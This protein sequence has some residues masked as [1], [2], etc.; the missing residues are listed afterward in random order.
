[1]ATI[2]ATWTDNVSVI[3]A[4][5]LARGSVSRTTL[6]LRTK[7]GA[8]LM[9]RLGRG[10]TTALSAGVN[11]LARRTLNNAGIVHPVPVAIFSSQITAA[12]ST[13]I[14][15]DSSSGQNSLNVAST[16]GF[17][18]GQFVCIQDSGGGVTR[19]EFGRVSKVSGGAVVL[20]A[21]LQYSHTAVQADTVRNYAEAYVFWIDGGATYEVIID[22]GPQST[23]DTLTIEAKA[24]TY[25]SD[26][27]S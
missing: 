13:T 17:S 26:A 19:L 25:D 23:G 4:T 14:S 2:T 7:R 12:S 3:A 6:D 21:P 18:E 9:V 24:Q 15:S 8:F 27:S 20:D 10:G 22:Y 5:T 11:V 1:M 16:S